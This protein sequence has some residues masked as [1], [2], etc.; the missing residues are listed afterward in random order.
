[1]A[2]KREQVY[3]VT[4]VFP[5]GVNRSVFV[6][7]PNRTKAERRALKKYPNAIHVDRSPFPQS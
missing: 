4:L 1:M 7:A 5:L 3:R 6:K 2:R